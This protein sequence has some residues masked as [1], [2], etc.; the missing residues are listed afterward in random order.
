MNSLSAGTVL[1]IPEDPVYRSVGSF[2]V[3]TIFLQEQYGEH[4]IV[5]SSIIDEGYIVLID[6]DGGGSAFMPFWVVEHCGNQGSIFSILKKTVFD[7]F[8]KEE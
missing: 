1:S 4:V 3:K 6:G 7:I 5:T 2:L 8:K